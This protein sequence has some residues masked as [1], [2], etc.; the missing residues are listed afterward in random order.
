MKKNESPNWHHLTAGDLKKRRG[1]RRLLALR[2]REKA[3]VA[4]ELR[5][6][7]DRNATPFVQCSKLA[8]KWGLH[9]TSAYRCLQRLVKA[10]AAERAGFGVHAHYRI[11]EKG[12]NKMAWLEKRFGG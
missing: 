10:G 7:K 9:P 12:K 1:D 11:T 6:K 4:Y 5:K 8:K 2:E 3:E